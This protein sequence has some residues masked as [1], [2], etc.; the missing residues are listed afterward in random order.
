MAEFKISRLR[1]TWRNQWTTSTSYNKD[2]VVRYGGSTW[3]CVRQHTASAFQTDQDFLANPGDSAPTPAW[4][5]MTDGYAWRG[6]W[7]QST[8]YNPGDIVLYGGVVYQTVV[9]HTSASTFLDNANKFAEYATTLSWTTDWQ[10]STRYGVGDLVRYN[11][12]VY[13]CIAEHTSGTTSQGLEIGNNDADDDSTGE[14]WIVYNKGVEF[15]GDYTSG[16]RYRLNDLVK[17]GGSIL[18]VITGHIGNG[19]SDYFVTEFA[20]YNYNSEW[21]SSAY[22]A[23]GDVVKH[24]GY[25]F[26]ANTNNTNTSPGLSQ[27]DTFDTNWSLIVKGNDFKGT[28]NSTTDY[29]SGDVVRRGGYL[30]VA[31]IDTELSAEDG[32]TLDYL[33]SSNWEIV[34][35]GDDWKNFWRPTV[36]YS[37]GDI[38]VFKGTTYRSNVEHVSSNENFP[39]DNGNGFYYWDIVLLA[40]PNVAL[41]SGGDLLSFGLQREL[42]GDGSTIGTTPVPIGS[43]NTTAIVTSD[44]TVGYKRRELI[45]KVRYVSSDESIASDDT[46]DPDRG[47]DPNKPYRTIRHACE[48][49]LKLGDNSVLHTIKIATGEYREVLPIRVPAGTAIEGSELRSATVKPNLA[50]SNLNATY[51]IAG[52]SRVLSM[53]DAILNQT[54]VTPSVGNNTI[55]VTNTPVQQVSFNPRQ[56]VNDTGPTFGLEIFQPT[57]P[58]NTDVV[59]GDLISDINQYITFELLSSG[60]TPTITGSND[61]TPISYANV[62]A[63]LLA[64]KQ[65]MADEVAAY[66]AAE[67]PAY[68]IDYDIIRNTVKR[69]IDAIIS[70]LKYPGNWHS[71]EEGRYFRNLVNG[72]A[73]DDM[74]YL[75][76]TTGVRNLTTKDLS[77]TLNPPNVFELYRRPTGGA[78]MSLDPGWGPEHRACWITSRS[79]YVQNVTTFG[80]NCVGQKIDGA[81]HAGGN[82]SIVSNDFTQVCSDGIGAWVLNNGRAELVSVF[83]YYAQIGMFAEDGGVIRATNGNS[84]YGDYGAIADGNDPTETPAFAEVNNRTGQAIVESAFAGEINDEILILEY[85]HAGENYSS[86]NYTFQGSGVGA[87]VVQ[88]EFRDNAVFEAL[89]KN[90]VGDAGATEG[91]LGYYEQGNNAQSGTATSLVIATNDATTE[92]KALGLRLIITSGQGAGQYGYVTS[93]NPSTKV[94][95][96]ARESDDQPGWDHVIPGTPIQASLFTDNTYR[97]EARPTFSHPGF[98]SQLINLGSSNTWIAVAYGETREIYNGVSG[99]AGTGETINITPINA[100]FNVI[101]NKRRYEIT[102]NQGGAGYEVGQTVTILGSDVGG[103]DGEHNIVITVTGTTDDSTNAVTGFRHVGTANSGRFVAT[104][105]SGNVSSYSLD[106]E[107]WDTGTLPTSGNWKCLATGGTNNYRF[108]AIRNNSNQGAISQDGVTWISRTLPQSGLWNGLAYGR[109]DNGNGAEVFLAVAGDG[110]KGIYSIDGGLTWAT[111]TLPDIGDSSFNEWVDVAYGKGKFV[112]VANSGNFAAVGTYNSVTDTWTWEPTIM[113]TIADSTVKDWRSIAYGNNKFLTISGTGEIAYSFNGEDWLS[114]GYMPTQDGSTAHNWQKVRYGQGVFFAIGDNGDR[115]I[116]DDAPIDSTSNFAAT[117]ESGILWTARTLSQSSTWTSIGFGN[118]DITLGDSTAQSNSTGMWIAVATGLD[119]GSKILTGART[120]GRCIVE[121]GSIDHI[122]IWEPGSGYA[123]GS[124]TITIT[125]PNSTDPAYVEIRTGDAV[126]AQPGWINRG[127]GYRTSSTRVTLLGDGFAD[128]IPNGQFVTVSG[129]SILPGP[130]TQ[131]RFRGVTDEFYT[132]QTIELLDTDESGLLTA[133]FRI[134]PRL[135]LDYFLEHTS[136]VEIRERYSQVRITGHDF[137][138][139]GTGNFVETN[140]PVIYSSGAAFEYAPENEVVELDGGRVFYTSTDQ[141]G[142]FRVGEL[143]AVEQATGIVT[144]SADFFDFGGLTELALGGVRL[145]GS[146]AVVREFSTDPLFIQDSNNVVPTQRAIKAYLQNRLNVGGSDLLTASFIAGTVRVGPNLISNVA[147]L[148][149]VFPVKV[150]YSGNQI[151]ISGS[152]LAQTMFFDSFND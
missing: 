149:I 94:V 33:D 133:R 115:I 88:E 74:F 116:G 11:G 124:P 123:E 31:L 92:A 145:G 71:V 59:I 43:A 95:T 25:L 35:P 119:H 102:L 30:Y 101:K 105:S 67:Y 20:G 26:K 80:T 152:M 5:K 58:A 38:V 2:D 139:V 126:L 91:G 61:L 148:E 14:H 60:T 83:T 106:G 89:I 127:S 75:R 21:I 8:L 129:I 84:S 63:R 40:G 12:I 81:L 76:D 99:D 24:G 147:S 131:F 109:G 130:G 73:S 29:K 9:S 93:L 104:P 51:Q 42:V 66:L 113:D 19:F 97:F 150:D 78:F 6:E 15:V 111:T 137:L 118:P 120:Q 47:K 103:V 140:Y 108:V 45:N 151:G 16:I 79:P 117:S 64:N 27:Y 128:V 44:G 41:S 146:G 144:I 36:N 142:N 3:V 100:T 136:Q 138:D 143:F 49:I 68:A 112:A 69:V 39:G 70:D 98:T 37:L 65:F 54:P 46:S 4:I 77:G 48:E 17:Y 57:I 50:N 13:E 90:A 86:A 134:T 22:Y 96:V 110:D 114:G 87:S 18:R 141:N 132:V 53:I 72:S 55:Q 85:R 107:T 10:P 7:Q 32:S 28:W 82:K 122:R 135:T 62:E 52:Y 34:V 1:Y 125:D 121:A 23:I 56:F